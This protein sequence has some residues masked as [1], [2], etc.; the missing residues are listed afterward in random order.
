MKKD[1]G[2]MREPKRIRRAKQGIE[3]KTKEF[4]RINEFMKKINSP[5]DLG[6]FINPEHKEAAIIILLNKDA[7]QGQ[8]MINSGFETSLRMLQAL[9]QMTS[10]LKEDIK[11]KLGPLFD[12]IREE[13]EKPSRRAESSLSRALPSS[14]NDILDRLVKAKEPAKPTKKEEEKGKEDD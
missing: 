7:V 4:E 5:S 6:K 12:N 13:I 9:E 10:S 11:Q 8:I 1:Y 2:I 3:Y 14:V